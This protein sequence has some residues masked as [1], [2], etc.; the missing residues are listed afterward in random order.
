MWPLELELHP[1]I[2]DRTSFCLRNR[3]QQFGNQ[4]LKIRETIGNGTQHD[5]RDG[6]S[7]EMLL[8]GEIPVD[9]DEHVELFRGHPKQ[10]PVLDGRPSHLARSLDF[11]ADDIAREPP[12]DAL[13]DK[14]FH[15]AVATRRSFA[16]SR[17]SMTCSR[18]TEGNPARKSSID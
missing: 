18:L 16:C 8:E 1:H 4:R 12:I 17:N 5:D 7:R 2:G 6:E 15:E 10:F 11:V 3:R 14:Y 9:G 13:V